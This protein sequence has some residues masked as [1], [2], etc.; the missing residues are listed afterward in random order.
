M[1][2]APCHGGFAQEKLCGTIIGRSAA[3]MSTLF[4]EK[5]PYSTWHGEN[6]C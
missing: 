1:A 2:F 6:K 4:S 3:V 5:N